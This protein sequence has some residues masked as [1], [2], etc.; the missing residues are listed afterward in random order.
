MN[1]CYHKGMVS[2]VVSNCYMVATRDS[3]NPAV[4]YFLKMMYSSWLPQ[5]VIKKYEHVI[6]L[7][8]LCN[9]LVH[10]VDNITLVVDFMSTNSYD[11]MINVSKLHI[12]VNNWLL[13]WEE[14]KCWTLLNVDDDWIKLITGNVESTVQKSHLLQH[15]VIL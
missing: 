12:N 7:H 5:S 9:F 2:N 13:R 8:Q 1:P 11:Q 15:E 4:M 14:V 3:R 10:C 6:K